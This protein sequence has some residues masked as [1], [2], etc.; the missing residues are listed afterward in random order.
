MPSYTRRT[1]QCVVRNILD[2]EDC[3]QAYAYA[4]LFP[5]NVSACCPG[6]VVFDQGGFAD[7]FSGDEDPGG[8]GQRGD[9]YVRVRVHRR[10]SSRRDADGLCVTHEYVQ[11]SEG[12]SE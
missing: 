9:A 12:K 10:G 11:E 8:D 5:A 1:R 7:P 3:D 4:S 2:G 6:I